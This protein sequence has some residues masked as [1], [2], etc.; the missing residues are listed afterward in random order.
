MLQASY[1]PLCPVALHLQRHYGG[2]TF[3]GESSIPARSWHTRVLILQLDRFDTQQKG[4]G[5]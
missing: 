3:L 5:G 2:W 1:L 4:G